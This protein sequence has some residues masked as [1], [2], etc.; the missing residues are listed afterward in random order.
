MQRLNVEA[1]RKQEA[2]RIATRK[3][4]SF[5]ARPHNRMRASC[6]P[7]SCAPLGARRWLAALL[8]VGFIL[9]LVLLGFEN[10]PWLRL[11][12]GVNPF[13]SKTMDAG[14]VLQY[15]KA[16]MWLNSCVAAAVPILH[17]LAH[18]APAATYSASATPGGIS[19]RWVPGMLLRR[20][21]TARSL[22]VL[23]GV[24][25]TNALA[26]GVPYEY[27]RKDKSP[28]WAKSLPQ[29]LAYEVSNCEPILCNGHFAVS[30]SRG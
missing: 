2:V 18:L 29:S 12:G 17:L 27:Y 7:A 14:C 30:T 24:L 5:K 20:G 23:L 13:T 22:A 3:A 9:I 25:L 8:G 15:S 6:G 28:D 19:H 4:A 26:F 10:Y 21:W 11:P 16:F 1:G